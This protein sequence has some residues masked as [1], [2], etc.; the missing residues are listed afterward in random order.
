MIK[1][2]FAHTTEIDN[3]DA[4]LSR[5][6]DQLD[7]EGGLFRHSVGI[8]YYYSDFALTGVVQKLCSRFDFPIVGGTT[9]NSAVPGSGE[10]MNLTLT[11]LTSDDCTFSAGLSDPLSQDPFVPVEK[12]YR[13]LAG[14]AGEKPALF[15]IMTPHLLEVTGDDYLAAL[16]SLSGGV[17]VFGS[18]AFTHTVDFTNVK[19]CFNGV[20]YKDRL[21]LIAFR[22]NL[23][24]RFFCS[25]IPEER[26]IHQRAF[27]TDSYKNRIR[28]ING[29]PA[30]QYLE[31]IGLSEDGKLLGIA[32]F[33]LVVYTGDGSRLIRTIFRNEGEELLCSGSMPVH[34][35][36][37]ISFC[38]KEFV[39]ESAKKTAQEY[40]ASGEEGSLAL[41]ISCAA[42]RWTLGSD[43]YAEIR[44]INSGFEN[45]P[46]HFAYSAGEFCPMVNP[47]GKMVN[48]F[49]NYSLSVCII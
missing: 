38:D 23:H 34:T 25:T 5:I 8:L 36:L 13:Q 16:N 30:M 33:P 40:I 20:E 26:M 45:L 6:H 11:I 27:I 49:L 3:V 2:L 29:I 37:G 14:D 17:P 42:R 32:T 19:T 24:P 43:A 44:A 7:A 15:F 12:L 48:G 28:K 22:G 41:I 10:S 31:S 1:M 9:S 46:Y 21:A 35:S 4:A 18:A 47:V 39:I